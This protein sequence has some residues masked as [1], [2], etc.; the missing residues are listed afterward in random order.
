[1]KWHNNS[2]DK[3]Q[4]LG[5]KDSAVS[6][7]LKTYISASKR[8][9]SQDTPNIGSAALIPDEPQANQHLLIRPKE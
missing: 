8:R 9:R 7:A 2:I 1:L 6:R 4:Q 5:N 3:L